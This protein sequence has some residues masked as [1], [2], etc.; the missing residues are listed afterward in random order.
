[1]DYEF[2]DR[3]ECT[4]HENF[5]LMLHERVEKLEE[6]FHNIKDFMNTSVST[7]ISKSLN[8]KFSIVLSINKILSAIELKNLLTQSYQFILLHTEATKLALV[9]YYDEESFHLTLDVKL[10]KEYDVNMLFANYLVQEFVKPI[11]DSDYTS[12]V[13]DFSNEWFDIIKSHYGNSYY[14]YFI[15]YDKDQ[16]KSS[17]LNIKMDHGYCRYDSSMAS[18]F[19]DVYD[20]DPKAPLVLRFNLTP[21]DS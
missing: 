9:A 6:R 11:L 21:N 19:Y 15:H 2:L 16:A 4:E 5:L 17:F 10:N 8:T 12:Y 1:M 14:C 20:Y 7:Y 3:K 13:R 18:L